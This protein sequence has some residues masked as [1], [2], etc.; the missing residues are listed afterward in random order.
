MGSAVFAGKENRKSF[1]PER[2]FELR[3]GWFYL[4]LLDFFGVGRD[5]IFFLKSSLSSL[6]LF[7]QAGQFFAALFPFKGSGMLWQNNLLDLKFKIA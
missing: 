7:F 6:F 4:F 5:A 2:R 3:I 1:P